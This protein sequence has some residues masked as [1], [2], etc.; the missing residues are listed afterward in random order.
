MND[1][2]AEIFKKI[3]SKENTKEVR[4]EGASQAGICLREK[5]HRLISPPSSFFLVTRA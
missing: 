1:F 2:L 5:G 3:G 4:G